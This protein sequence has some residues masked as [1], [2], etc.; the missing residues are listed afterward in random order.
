MVLI[1]Y[2]NLKQHKNATEKN[3][4]FSIFKDGM[5]SDT[6]DSVADPNQCKV[7]YNLKYYDG[8]LK[9]GL[10]FQDLLVPASVDNL[11]DTHTFDFASVIDK[12]CGIWVY[13]YYIASDTYN[14]QLYLIDSEYKLYTIPMI[15]E[16]SGYIFLRTERLS[17]YPTFYCN[18][19][20]YDQ[21]LSIFFANEGAVAVSNNIIATLKDLPAFIS[22]VVHYDKFFGV[23]NSNGNELVYS[24]NLDLSEWS[25]D[26]NS[27]IE[28]LDNR[29]AFKTLV[30]LNDYVFL[31]RE[32]G[33]T[34]IS[35][36]TSKDD[37]S[38][39]HLYT[40]PSKIYEDSVCVCGEK[41][42]FMTRDGLY[43][44]NGSSVD[45]VCEDFDRYF[46]NLD[47]MNC[48][49]AC[50]NGKY[51]LATKCDFSDEQLIGSE[52][53]TTYVN[54]VLFEVNIETL[55]VNI[56]RGVD[57][58][59]LVA[60]DNP[61]MSKLCACFYTDYTQQ[62]GELTNSGKTFASPTEKCWTS[63][64]TDLNYQGK[65]KKI[66]EIIITTKYPIDVEIESDEETK[67][68][69]F[70]GKEKEQRRSVSVLGK[71]FQ[72]TFRTEQADCDI[73]KPSVVFDVVE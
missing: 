43:T 41:V 60:V 34:K 1:F 8:A 3:L 51:Y 66:K 29:G 65:R 11:E 45:K 50:L 64:S 35:L 37:F 55:N 10:G 33:I 57:I 48:T 62:V 23:T 40:S 36:Y 69:S 30:A 5:V 70:E 73:K 25:D 14:Y 9:T 20:L 27:T 39:T 67:T 47:N 12:I 22:C 19:R 18:Y 49:S 54:N 72:F 26:N 63:F 68:F 46:K 28:F 52:N 4:T 32:Y 59:K 61:Y 38:F 53:T 42:F 58:R 24:S 21:N 71:T 2:K 44:F 56:Y 13:R 17:S 31:F 7:F 15:D 16:N 6:D